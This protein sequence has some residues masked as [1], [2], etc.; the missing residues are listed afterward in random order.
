MA[1][2]KKSTTL[3]SSHWETYSRNYESD[4]SLGT[5]SEDSDYEAVN[6]QPHLTINNYKKNIINIKTDFA[7]HNS[8]H[9]NSSSVYDSP[10]LKRK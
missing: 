9:S 10:T 4:D 5:D 1:V 7:R 8:I 6:K 2:Y 3:K